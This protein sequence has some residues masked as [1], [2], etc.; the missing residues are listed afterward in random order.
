MIAGF[1]Y[2]VWEYLLAIPLITALYL[3][4]VFWA[5]RML[6]LRAH[7]PAEVKSASGQHYPRQR[8][9]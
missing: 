2:P 6:P 4:A 7:R 3:G 9:S 8:S 5:D 1:S